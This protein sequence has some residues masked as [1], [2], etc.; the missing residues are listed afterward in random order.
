MHPFQYMRVAAPEEAVAY[1]AHAGATFLAGGTGLVDLMKEGAERHSLL[2]DVNRLP[3]AGI[4]PNGDGVRIGALARNSDVAND[5]LIR[6]QYPL[7]SQAIR[8]G[9]SAQLRNM[10]TVGGNVMQR[11][12]CLYF[13][14]LAY[15]CNK[16][17]PGSGCPAI[18]GF[19]RSHAIFGTSDSCVATHPSDMCVALMALDAVV[20]TRG[21]NGEGSIPISDFYL[22]PGE[23]PDRET[24]LEP[25]ELVT[26]VDLPASVGGRAHYLK[27]RDRASYE[28]ALVSVAAVLVVQDGVIQ[29]ARLA[30]GGVAPRPWRLHGSEATLIGQRPG[31]AVYREA[32]ERAVEGARPLAY[33]GFKIELLTR[34]IVRA[35]E[36]VGGPA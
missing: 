5:A 27:V 34:T 26:S 20:Q 31:R 8:A 4:E 30:A 28:F 35:L 15:P 9:A 3:L 13:R 1:A 16:R 23:T 18:R 33:N 2:I 6:Q 36:Q 32:A 19:N 12:R 25:G 22:L 21:V 11:T 24:V 14:D 17:D 10:A 29:T 7:V